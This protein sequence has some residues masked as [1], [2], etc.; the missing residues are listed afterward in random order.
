MD[1]Q[2][3]EEGYEENSD[4]DSQWLAQ[5]GIPTLSPNTSETPNVEKTILIQES[6]WMRLDSCGYFWWYGRLKHRDI[7]RI[8]C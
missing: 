5:Q 2:D 1:N 4:Y 7:E 3:G 6:S 8:G